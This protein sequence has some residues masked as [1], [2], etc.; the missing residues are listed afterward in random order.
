[1]ALG[2]LGLAPTIE[3]LRDLTP[4]DLE[5]LRSPVVKG[6]GTPA[7]KQ[8]RTSHHNLARLLAEGKK[9]AE[10][11]AITGYSPS[12]ISILQND[13][14]F[15]DLISYYK[16]QVQQQYLDAHSRLAVLGL[17]CAA[18]L[19]RRLDEEPDKFTIG[20]L[21]ETMET[22]LDRS[23]TPQAKAQGQPGGQGVSVTVNFVRPEPKAIPVELEGEAIDITPSPAKPG[24][25]DA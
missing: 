4:A 7:I 20:Q 12:R 11:S 16:T 23:L 10:V 17:D 24:A 22:A 2:E 18:E 14:S 13:P 6:V 15:R 9:N 8:L 1:M 5:A 3:Y 21:R 25:A 19:Q